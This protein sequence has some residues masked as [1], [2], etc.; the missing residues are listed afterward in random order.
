M[1]I[2]AKIFY[3]TSGT[4]YNWLVLT[5]CKYCL[6][7][8]TSPNL[9]MLHQH[10]ARLNKYYLSSSQQPTTTFLTTVAIWRCWPTYPSSYGLCYINQINCLL[11]IQPPVFSF[12]FIT[13]VI[14]HLPSHDPNWQI[15][16]LN[17]VILLVC[18][19]EVW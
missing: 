12:S 8:Q 2:L 9:V 11:Q 5:C 17:L 13:A 1:Q 7:R 19:F 14:S 10:F 6:P 16:W 15:L 18:C 3:G 4:G